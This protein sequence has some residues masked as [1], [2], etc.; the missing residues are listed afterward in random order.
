MSTLEHLAASVGL[1]GW[2]FVGLVLA[3]ALGS[4]LGEVTSC[5]S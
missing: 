5:R 1:V 2:A 4:L 3:D